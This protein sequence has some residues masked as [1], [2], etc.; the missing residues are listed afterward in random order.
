MVPIKDGLYNVKYI[1]EETN[2]VHTLD[3]MPDGQY[4]V[5]SN[6]QLDKQDNNNYLNVVKKDD[7][8]L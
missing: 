3:S 8:N 4:R 5:V 2:K 1:N 7:Q 6:L